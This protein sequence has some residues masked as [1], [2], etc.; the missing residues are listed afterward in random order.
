MWKKMI[1][2]EGPVGCEGLY[3]VLRN[4]WKKGTISKDWRKGLIIWTY[5][6]RDRNNGKII[7]GLH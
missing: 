4:K 5:K 1:T 2:V 6:K 7:E 3:R